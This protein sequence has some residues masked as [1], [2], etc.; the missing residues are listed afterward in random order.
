MPTRQGSFRLFKLFGIEVFLH[1][2]W[3]LIVLYEIEV[4]HSLYTSVVWNI[5]ECLA[6]FSIVLMHEFGH[7]LACRSVGGQANLIVLW[8]F[9]GVAYV[10][11]PQ[12]PGAQL[13]SIA[14]G[15]LVNVILFPVFSVIWMLAHSAHLDDMVPNAYGFVVTIWQINLVLLIFNMLPIYPLDGGQILRSLL[16]FIMGRGASLM[17]AAIFGFLGVVG[18]VVFAIWSQSVWLGAICVFISLNCY[19][20]FMQARE[21][22]RL[23]KAP[24]HEGLACPNC[25]ISP[26][27]GDFYTCGKCREKFDP[28]ASRLVCPHCHTAYARMACLECGAISPLNEWAQGESANG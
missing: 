28:F 24:R 7:A 3:F 6:L 14:A 23:E 8:P 15:P 20:G 27:A 17:A 26:P 16:W 10:A 12:R 18:L 13:W 5:L 1:W 21:L 4:R 9:G 2:S 22:V 19:R 11:P 25:K